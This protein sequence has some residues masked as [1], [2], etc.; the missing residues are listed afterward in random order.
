L[1]RKP[2][3]HTGTRSQA[4]RL[5]SRQRTAKDAAVLDFRS[6]VKFMAA[7]GA[8]VVVAGLFLSRPVERPPEVQSE[9]VQPQAVQP[10]APPAAPTAAPSVIAP[11][12]PDN[13]QV[14]SP[15]SVRTIPIEKPVGSDTATTGGPA[16]EPARPA[17]Q[18]SA[19]D[20]RAARDSP[21]AAPAAAAQAAACDREACR[22]A[23]RSFDSATCTYQPHRRA[24]RR[25]C[26]K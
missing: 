9:A 11:A 2:F 10:Q 6:T 4:P 12:T 25:L 21:L 22:R 23:Y 1:Q 15:R 19:P 13:A 18:P 5:T 3:K 14:L 7:F 26:E 17:A 8:G 16:G 24:P 20:A